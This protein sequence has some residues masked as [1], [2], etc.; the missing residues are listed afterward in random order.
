MTLLYQNAVIL[1]NENTHEKIHTK[2]GI[3]KDRY[4]KAEVITVSERN[5]FI[6]SSLQQ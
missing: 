1:E 5:I 3:M 2:V 4:G 6:L